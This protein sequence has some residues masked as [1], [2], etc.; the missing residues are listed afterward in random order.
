VL[1][2][3]MIV[4]YASLM[5]A[6]DPLLCSIGVAMAG[7]QLAAL[8]WVSRRR[9]DESR[10]ML[11]DRG[12]LLGTSLGGLQTI[13]TLK[14]T[15]SEGDFFARWAGYHAKVVAAE[16]RLG[17]TIELL[18]AVPP[19]LTA[20]NTVAVLGIGALRVMDGRLSMGL[21]VAFQSLMASF[22]QPV[23]ELVRLGSTVQAVTG[24]MA[25]LDDV[26]RY[27]EDHP[28]TTPPE[29]RVEMPAGARL[30]GLVELRGLTFGYSRLEPPLIE[31]LDLVLRPGS[32][33]ALVG[34]SGSGKSTIAKLVTGLYPPWSGEVRFDGLL[35]SQI[36]RHVLHRSL[37]IVDQD[38]SLFE[39]T[40]RE[41]IALWDA[42]VPEPTV[43]QAARDAAIHDD[44]AARAGGY[45]THVEEG[46][47][48]FSG[49]QRQ[50]IEIARA[51]VGEPTLLVLDEAT[52]AL[53]PL[54]EARVDRNLRR[55]GCTCLIVAHRLSTIRDC[56]EIL[57]LERGRVVQRGT[58]DEMIRVPGP[59][60]SLI[61]A[62]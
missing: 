49:G 6:Y 28:F 38:I 34:G 55:R 59:Y 53:D 45:D 54:T 20:L 44:I 39:G 27:R 37:A 26:H 9:T 62:G 23:G 8:R 41:N 24:D 51:L 4:F 48:N 18:D 30:T 32:R 15:G 52:A 2:A 22:L 29:E 46:G 1:S 21:L 10:R 35:P 33:V 14:A 61:E 50:R 19:L 60:A 56:D 36:P 31:G 11:Q 3:L 17:A 58:H 42:T 40:V 13:E 25:R 43:V 47:R 16:Q 12:K 57:V 5:W 7:L